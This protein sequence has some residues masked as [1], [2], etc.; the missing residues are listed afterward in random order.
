M[1]VLALSHLLLVCRMCNPFFP[2]RNGEIVIFSEVVIVDMEHWECLV[3][4]S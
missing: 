2:S 3:L 4:K 1:S